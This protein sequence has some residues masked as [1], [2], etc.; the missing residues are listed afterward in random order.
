MTSI[1]LED[2]DNLDIGSHLKER[3]RRKGQTTE[4]EAS[5]TGHKEQ[6]DQHTQ[7]QGRS[8]ALAEEKDV[9]ATDSQPLEASLFALVGSLGSS[10]LIALG[11]VKHPSTGTFLKDKKMAKFNIDLL[12]VLKEKTRGNLSKEEEQALDSIISDLQLKYVEA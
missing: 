8:D 2:S 4:D 12:I 9:E 1:N 7:S 5:K 3:L 6:Q 10:A 11:L